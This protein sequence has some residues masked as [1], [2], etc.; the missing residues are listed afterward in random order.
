MSLNFIP[1][2]YIRRWTIIDIYKNY[3]ISGGLYSNDPTFLYKS[4]KLLMTMKRKVFRIIK[5]KDGCYFY[6]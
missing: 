6:V 3:T 5:S 2:R 1:L 4:Q